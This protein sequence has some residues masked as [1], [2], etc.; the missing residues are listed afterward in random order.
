MKHTDDATNFDRFLSTIT[1]RAG[2]PTFSIHKAHLLFEKVLR[3][4]QS[5]ALP[6]ADALSGAR[7][8]FAQVLALVRSLQ[9]PARDDWQWEAVGK[10]NSLRNQFSH[11]LEPDERDK[12]IETYV[13]FVTTGF[14]RP[15]PPASGTVGSPP[16]GEGP[17]YQAVDMVNA[18]LFGSIAFRLGVGND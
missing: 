12:K 2:D 14:G 11:R 4:F 9:P 17:F 15:L 5:K 16:A 1:Q 18:A 3:T 13:A 10:L 8:T 6:N 7:L